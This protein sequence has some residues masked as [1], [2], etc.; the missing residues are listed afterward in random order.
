MGFSVQQARIALAS[1]STGLD[2][3]AALDTLLSNGAGAPSPRHTPPLPTRERERRPAP[4]NRERER[5][6]QRERDTPSPQSL[7]QSQSQT[8]SIQEQ[9]DK[10]IAQASEIGLSVFNK[11]NAFWNQGKEKV[12]K[13]YEERAKSTAS[14]SGGGGGGG[15]RPKWM[16]DLEREGDEERASEG[17]AARGKGF[18][19]DASPP[20][21]PPPVRRRPKLEPAAP[22]TSSIPNLF[23]D[24]EPVAYVSPFRRGKPKPNPDITSTPPPPSRPV[25]IQETPKPQPVAPKRP[26]VPTPP[27]VLKYKALGADKFKLGQYGEAE[28]AYTSALDTYTSVAG[29]DASSTPSS[30]PLLIPLYNNRAL[31]RLKTGDY[32]GAI[33]DATKVIELVQKEGLEDTDLRDGLL[34]AWKRRAEAYEG[35]ER[36]DSARRDWESVAGSVWA[37]GAVRGE[38]VRGVGRCR[39][40]V[41]GV[42]GDTNNNNVASTPV[43]P[44]PKS[45]PTVK[46]IPPRPSAVQN[47]SALNA[48]RKANTQAEA[49]D[50]ERHEL[51]DT[52]D[53]RLSGW[54]AGKETNI[55][56]LIASL[57]TVLWPELGWVKIGM[58]ELVMPNQVKIRYTKAIAKVHPDKV[59]LFSMGLT[60]MLG[61]TLTDKF[62]V[63]CE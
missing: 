19:D 50:Q 27:T 13:A 17:G 43:K 34:K 1:T 16:Q 38:A 51:K 15:G 63:E 40:M 58:A 4:R 30:H 11:A 33:D 5:E 60:W 7:A 32:T 10:L 28:A 48:L 31:T 59:R 53:A 9:A 46:P 49:E 41:G 61:L 57:D 35:K 45:K 25:P 14:G 22:K 8:D 39:R 37:S 3:Q 18:S 29:D 62:A 44:K 20:S 2:V 56:A 6:R 21:S 52:V 12:Q 47:G 54:K 24:A 42:G 36:W 55:R 23:S 26:P